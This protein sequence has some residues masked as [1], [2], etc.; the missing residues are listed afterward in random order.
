MAIIIL[1]KFPLRLRIPRFQINFWTMIAKNDILSL[2]N[3]L[4]CPKTYLDKQIKIGRY[5][6]ISDS[7]HIYGR[8]FEK[9]AAE[10]P[11]MQSTSY[12][13]RAWESTHPVFVAM[14]EEMREKLCENPDFMLAQVGKG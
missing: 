10:I 5:V 12:K 8:N 1:E 11:K 4:Q 3:S 2:T 7:L 6:D 9:V 14:T 13:E